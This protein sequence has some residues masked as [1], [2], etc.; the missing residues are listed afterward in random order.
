MPTV[1][2][3]RRWLPMAVPGLVMLGLGL[4]EATR[5]VLSWDEVATADVAHRTAGQIAGLLPHIDG[6]FGPYYLL[7]HVWTAVFGASVLSLRLPSILAMAGAAALTGELGRRLFGA[8]AGVLAGLLLCLV[9]NMSRYA[10]EARPYAMVCFFSVLALLLLHRVID[11][12]SPGRWAWYGA[13]VLAVGLSSIVAMVVLTGHLALLL[14]RRRALLLPWSLVALVP[15]VALT[16]LIWWGL[17]QRAAQLHWVTPV[18]LG[19]V[20]AF[21]ARLTGSTEV[22]WLL[23]GLFLVAV[24]ARARAVAGMALV[25]LA[26][27]AAV[28]AVSATGTSFWVIRYLLFVLIPAAVVAAAGLTRLAGDRRWPG[29]AVALAVPLGVVAAAAVP[30]QIAV[31]QPNVKNGSDYRAMAALIRKRQ[32]AGDDIVLQKGRQMRAGLDYYLRGDRGRPRDVLES[33]SAARTHT[34]IAEEFPDAAARLATATRIWL[35]VAGHPKDAASDRPDLERLLHADFERA[36]QWTVSRGT[37]ALY[38]RRATVA[39]TG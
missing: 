5:P 31:R 28:L 10:A 6:V 35:V 39:P 29:L 22:A 3:C 16:P 19:A 14:V 7:M 21:P 37:L 36:A 9:P 24:L 2:V 11:R 20:Y 30:G 32:Q 13:A 34:L 15:L 27:A 17:H 26:P 23:I 4:F 38:I 25:A 12:P 8:P 18:T 1:H 33:R